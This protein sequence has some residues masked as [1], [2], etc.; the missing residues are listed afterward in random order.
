MKDKKYFCYEI[1][2]NIAVWSANG[3]IGYNPCSFYD[4]YFETSDQINLTNAWNSNGRKKIIELI[5]QDK[6]IA[7]CHRCYE[8]ESRGITSRRLHAKESYE[9]WHQNTDIDLIGPQGLDY[10]VGNLCNLK[11]TICGPHNSSMWVL[12]YE[13]LYPN[14]NIETFKYQKD[15]QIEIT[16]DETLNNVISLHFHGGGEPLLSEAHVN[17]LKKIKSIKG[18]SD[19]RVFYNTNGTVT[20]SEE[21]LKLWEECKLIELY[22]SIDDIGARFEYQRPG[23]SFKTIEENLQ[24]YY[25]NMPHNHMF[26]INAVWSYLNFY[27]LDQLTDWYEENLKTN[28]YGDPVKLIFQTVN[29]ITQIHHVSESVQDHLL[30]KFQN[31]PNLITLV[32]SLSITDQSHRGFLEWIDKLDQIR[33][34]K[35]AQVAPEWAKLLT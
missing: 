13:K 4:G 31:Y 18:L 1:F 32:N 20:V 7:G 24:W 34:Q 3:R 23:K 12:D 26:N 30:K 15:Q 8:D 5:N 14:Q 22:F 19:V 27:Y 2:K 28:R 11:C 6:P 9:I 21:V 33:N 16:N 29:G 10:S 35:F 17:L 25:K